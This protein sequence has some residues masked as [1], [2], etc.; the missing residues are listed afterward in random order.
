MFF[1]PMAASRGMPDDPVPPPLPVPM[2]HCG[3]PAQVKQSRDEAT[4]GRI[5]YTCARKW[6]P[7]EDGGPSQYNIAPCFFHEWIDGPEK[8]DPRI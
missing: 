2:C 6:I 3:I 7:N 4:T 5:F 1:R 8:Y